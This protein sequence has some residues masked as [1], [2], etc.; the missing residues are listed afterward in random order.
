MSLDNLLVPNN[1]NL[2]CGTI[3][4]S[5]LPDAGFL[6]QASSLLN[7]SVN[8]TIADNTD[9]VI[10][11]DDVDNDGDQPFFYTPGTGIFTATDTCHITGTIQTAFTSNAGGAGIVFR[12]KCQLNNTVN[13]GVVENLTSAV[14]SGLMCTTFSGR[15]IQ[16]NTFKI[17]AYQNTGAPNDIKSLATSSASHTTLS[18]IATYV[19]D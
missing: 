13:F 11:Y 2:F 5:G 18:L 15:F 17:V 19:G 14:P 7:L 10:L 12:T 4:A 3:N 1:L 9:T 16:G 8:Q 6:Q